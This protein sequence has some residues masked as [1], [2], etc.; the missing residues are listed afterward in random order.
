MA[1]V[2]V[3]DTSEA[4]SAEPVISQADPRVLG[5]GSPISQ[6]APC[7]L[8]GEIRASQAERAGYQ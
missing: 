8:E 1:V 7:I 2:L 4:A 6:A 5:V 3:A